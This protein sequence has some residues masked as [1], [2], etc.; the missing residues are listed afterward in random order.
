MPDL[1]YLAVVVAAVAAFVS[2][3][4]YYAVFAR[5][6]QAVSPAARESAQARPEPWK[7]GVQFLTGLVLTL[8]VA[9]FA[10]K[11]EITTVGGGVL[12]ALA[13]WVG[14]PATL[15]VGA[16]M[17]E[18]SPWRLAALHAGDWLLKLLVVAVIVS[19]WR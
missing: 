4:V 1:N 16:M 18:K 15:W 6:Y 5:Q 8:V 11:L 3:F 9:G 7:L 17:W 13:L 2:A 12:L 19:V 10:A 14:F